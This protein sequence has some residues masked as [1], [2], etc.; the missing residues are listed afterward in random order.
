[1]A[2]PDKNVLGTELKTCSMDP[3]TGWLRDGCCNTDLTD[4]GIHTVCGIMTDEFLSYLKIIGNDLSTPVP[5]SGF[6]GLVAGDSWCLCAWAWLEA[7][8]NGMACKV[9]LEATHEET[10]VMIPLTALKEYSH[11]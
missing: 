11:V 5:E 8:K 6:K 10:L 7:Y 2:E 4:E 9:N 1:M 3:L